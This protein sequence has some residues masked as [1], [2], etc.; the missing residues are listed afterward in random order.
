M[1]TVLRCRSQRAV[2]DG[3]ESLISHVLIA[4]ETV[5]V[6][7]KGF[8]C[9]VGDRAGSRVAER[10]ARENARGATAKNAIPLGHTGGGSAWLRQR[11]PVRNQPLARG[12]A[13]A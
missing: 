7:A 1:H 12:S 9:R 11:E 3:Y 8:P 10:E 13:T 6:E 5:M 4:P 2:L